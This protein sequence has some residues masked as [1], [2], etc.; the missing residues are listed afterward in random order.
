MAV[1]KANGSFLKA[2]GKILVRPEGG[3]DFVVIGGRKYPFV[4]IGDRI[5]IT[6]NL[7]FIFDGL[8]IG[9][10]Y[11]DTNRNQAWYY[12]N[13][14][15]LYGWDAQRRGLLYSGYTMEYMMNHADS[16]F[17]PGWRIPSVTDYNDLIKRHSRNEL[18]FQGGPDYGSWSGTNTSGFNC[19]PSGTSY[20][21]YNFSEINSLSLQW[22]ST[23]WDTGFYYGKYFTLSSIDQYNHFQ[24]RTGSIRL[25]KDA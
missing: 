15:S 6:E 22:T 3:G 25:V 12:Q 21:Y 20:G 18:C 13:N 9:D 16:L 11:N 4:R 10:N 14:E 2:N 1:L 7:D 8:F 17:P 23:K 24:Y 5:W 19:K